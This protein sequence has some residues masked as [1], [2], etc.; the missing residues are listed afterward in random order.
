VLSHIP[1][2]TAS[3]PL[4]T[5]S[6]ILVANSLNLH[7]CLGAIMTN[8]R[9]QGILDNS[10]PVSSFSL[11]QITAKTRFPP[12]GL[13]TLQLQVLANPRDG[14]NTHHAHCCWPFR[15]VRHAEGGA[16]HASGASSLR[17]AFRTIPIHF[18]SMSQMAWDASAIV[19]IVNN[20]RHVQRARMRR[21]GKTC[22]E[23]VRSDSLMF[24]DVRRSNTVGYNLCLCKQND[25]AVC[26]AIYGFR[27]PCRPLGMTAVSSNAPCL[28]C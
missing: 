24:Q 18:A 15:L 9:V 3:L 7:S 28:R 19:V 6:L 11:G 23:R 10:P 20:P 21:V 25:D 16:R 8:Q 2:C 22:A 26:S 5:R 4:M 14:C 12:C 13:V 17:H 27:S 1:S